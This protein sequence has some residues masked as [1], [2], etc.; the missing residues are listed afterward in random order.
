MRVSELA[1]GED[2]RARLT[3]TEWA[4]AN[5]AFAHYREIQD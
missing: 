2:T 1:D 5:T 4:E 3:G